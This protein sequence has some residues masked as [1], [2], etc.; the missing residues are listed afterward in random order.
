MPG[1]TEFPGFFL[2]W[3]GYPA[4]GRYAVVGADR[5]GGE[6]HGTSSRARAQCRT[7]HPVLE[8][9]L[10][11]LQAVFK[12]PFAHS[13]AVAILAQRLVQVRGANERTSIEAYRAGLYHDAGR[14]LV[15]IL[16]L[17]IER[18]MIEL[19]GRKVFSE[20]IFAAILDRAHG[21]ASGRL[22]RGFG[23]SREVAEAIE[24]AT[25]PVK[26]GFDLGMV[27]R[28]AN[29][30]SHLGGFHTRRDEMDKARAAIDEARHAAG[31]DET[32]CHRVLDGIKDAVTRR[33]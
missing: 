12:Q 25:L 10:P 2:W 19:K 32:T 22:A 26:Q 29:A 11:R 4:C 16:L 3:H 9:N 6:Q 23:L 24:N 13:L 5:P 8:T 31:I 17:E 30:L 18:N 7:G 20:D 15:A 27:I 33:L 21:P 14:P 28:L 1:S